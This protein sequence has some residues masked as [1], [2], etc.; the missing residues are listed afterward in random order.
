MTWEYPAHLYLKRAKSNQ[1][2]LGTAYRHRA[3]LAELV[4]LRALSTTRSGRMMRP[5]TA[6]RLAARIE[7]RKAP[8]TAWPTRSA[9]PTSSSCRLSP[10]DGPC[11]WLP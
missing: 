5:E 7:R 9:P 1:L 6:I 4:D 3:Q 8:T 10:A 11:C 2:A